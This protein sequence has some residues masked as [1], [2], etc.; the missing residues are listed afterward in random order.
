MRQCDTSAGVG[1]ALRQNDEPNSLHDHKPLEKILKKPLIKASKRR[2]NMILRIQKY[3]FTLFYKPGKTIH[4][5][6]TLSRAHAA[7][8][9]DPI[10]H[11]AGVNVVMTF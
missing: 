4:L 5:K 6:D 9:K 3:D 8:D 11:Q 2:Q 1:A 7:N 10:M